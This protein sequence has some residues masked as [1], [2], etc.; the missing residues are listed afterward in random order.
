[1]ASDHH[2]EET[3]G[4]PYDARLVRRLRLGPPG[5]ARPREV[6]A[7]VLGAGGDPMFDVPL[8]KTRTVLTG[9]S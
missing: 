2:D 8:K 3:L 1:M 5:A 4:K 6:L 7:A 9:P